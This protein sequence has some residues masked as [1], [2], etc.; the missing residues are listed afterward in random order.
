L[1]VYFGGDTAYTP[2]A[3]TETHRRF[4]QLDVALL[5][6]CPDEPREFMEHTH[7]G[8]RQAVDAFALLGADTMVPMHFDTFIN[9]DDDVGHCAEALQR[10]VQQR[11][12]DNER[13][14]ILAIGEQ[15]VLIPVRP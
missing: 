13:V 8:P 1:T 12:L 7:M 15:R 14:A 10:A 2:T 5:P 9:S 3:F 4:P 6:I 11:H